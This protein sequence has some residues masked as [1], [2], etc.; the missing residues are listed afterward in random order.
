MKIKTLTIDTKK[1]LRNPSGK[2]VHGDT[3]RLRNGKGAMCCLG[4]L[5]Q[6]CGVDLRKANESDSPLTPSC[7]SPADAAKLPASV[8]EKYEDMW[9]TRYRNTTWAAEAMALNDSNPS[10]AADA[11]KTLAERKFRLKNHFKKIG[12][13]LRFK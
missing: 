13:T 3:S 1:W 10:S 4:F 12:I 6:A 11:P 2:G 8:V 7:L 5:A 9:S